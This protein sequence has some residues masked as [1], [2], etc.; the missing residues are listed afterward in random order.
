MTEE[1]RD[2]ILAAIWRG[3]ERLADALEKLSAERVSQAIAGEVPQKTEPA[4]EQPPLPGFAEAEWKPPEIDPKKPRE[5]CN[6]VR[7]W[8]EIFYR[9]GSNMIPTNLVSLYLDG[10]FLEAVSKRTNGKVSPT[11]LSKI[12][13]VLTRAG[14]AK[15]EGRIYRVQMPTDELRE[16]VERTAKKRAAAKEVT[17]A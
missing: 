1:G 16:A 17:N 9:F 6:T 7:V 13:S 10:T 14:A 3:I 4:P 2:K 8:E 11:S 5:W 12:M 15:K